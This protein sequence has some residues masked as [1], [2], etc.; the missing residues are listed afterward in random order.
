[1]RYGKRPLLSRET[2]SAINYAWAK[3][4]SSVLSAVSFLIACSLSLSFLLCSKF[5]FLFKAFCEQVWYYYTTSLN[6]K[7]KEKG[8][9]VQYKLTSCLKQRS[10][11]ILRSV[12]SPKNFAIGWSKWHFWNCSIICTKQQSKYLLNDLSAISYTI[13][14]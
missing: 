14:L 3:F 12:H 9:P 11:F 8:R 7:H 5:A 6:F 4:F 1:M 10:S 2:H 13:F